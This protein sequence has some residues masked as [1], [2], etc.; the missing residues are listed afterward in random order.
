LSEVNAEALNLIETL[1][2]I[3]GKDYKIEDGLIN[4]DDSVLKEKEEEAYKL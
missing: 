4:I 3:N 1:G 2:L